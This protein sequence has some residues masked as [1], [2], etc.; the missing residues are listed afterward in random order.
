MANGSPVH[1]ALS[2]M[3]TT[4]GDSGQSFTSVDSLTGNFSMPVSNNIY[5]YSIYVNNPG[6]GPGGQVNNVHPGQSGVIINLGTNGGVTADVIVSSGWNLISVPVFSNDQRK[7]TLFPSSVSNAFAYLPGNGYA[8]DETLQ[9]GSGYWLKFGG[10]QTIALNGYGSPTDTIP[11]LAGWN[12]IGSAYSMTTDSSINS[13]PGSLQVESIFQY[14]PSGYNKTDTL[15]AGQGYWV[16]VSENGRI[17]L[18]V[19]P[20][21]IPAKNPPHAILKSQ[22]SKQKRSA[23]RLN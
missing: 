4:A 7:S 2:L 23:L 19:P 13:I 17:I 21:K 1:N 5:N 12:L 3:A 14:G 8:L 22:L 18:S 10:P 6:N 16:K 15:Q 9:V 20:G 11:V